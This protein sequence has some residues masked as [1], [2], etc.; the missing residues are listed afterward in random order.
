[1]RKKLICILVTAVLLSAWCFRPLP[2]EMYQLLS[3]TRGSGAD[4]NKERCQQCR[5]SRH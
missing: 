4:T 3:K 2:Q 1:M 5:V